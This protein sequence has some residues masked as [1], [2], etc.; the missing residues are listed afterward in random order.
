MAT[1]HRPAALS[2]TS[3][4][5]ESTGDGEE[6]TGRLKLG[7]RATPFGWPRPRLYAVTL[8]IGVAIAL[9]LGVL[10]SDP[11][12]RLGGDFLAFYAAG[13]TVRDA[14]WD[15][16]YDPAVQQL[17]Q[18]RYLDEG[19]LPFAYPPIVAIPY[20]VLSFLPFGVAYL[21][22]AAFLT[23]V[24]ALAV[25][26]TSRLAG[27]PV[28]PVVGLAVALTFGPIY[29]SWLGGQNTAIVMAI[30]AGVAILERRGAS[31]LAGLV[32]ALLMFKPQYGLALGGVLLLLR[33]RR[34]IGGWILGLAA[35]WSASAIVAG[36]GWVGEWASY[37]GEFS[38]MNATTNRPNFV[39]LP[40]IGD[41][42]APGGAGEAVGLVAA[43]VLAIVV[44]AVWWY[45]A[46]DLCVRYAVLGAAM[47]LIAPQALFYDA[48]ISAM[49][50]ALLA[51]RVPWGRWALLAMWVAGLTVM[52][53]A[54][55]SVSPVAVCT[56]GAMVVVALMARTTADEPVGNVA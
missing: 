42:L 46:D 32:A 51:T 40:G 36:A 38:E 44:A 27:R 20:V 47:V 56:I 45:R 31:F 2:T 41:A 54:A 12:E 1:A 33:D 21:V 13:E 43:A 18:S 16:L 17:V 15:S 26:L 6:G 11:G 52:V 35:M 55:F 3:P 5:T 53:R 22:H 34:M 7:E 9:P 49:A 37:L 39:S 14:G 10:L 25:W 23:G 29:S 48:G 30:V 24:L 50:V 4:M 28:D 8:L 19:F